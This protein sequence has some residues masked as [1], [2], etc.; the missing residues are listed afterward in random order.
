MSYLVRLFLSFYF[1]L[2]KQD[3]HEPQS[4]T[5]RTLPAKSRGRKHDKAIIKSHHNSQKTPSQPSPP[6]SSASTQFGLT[7][8][9]SAHT[10]VMAAFHSVPSQSS[11]NTSHMPNPSSYP[12]LPPQPSS[13]FV[14][15]MYWPPPNAFLHGPYPSTYACQSFPSTANYTSIQTQPYYN[16]HTS[17]SSFPKLL[18]E[19]NAKNDPASEES[20]NDSNSS[21]SAT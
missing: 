11:Q 19:G 13:A 8:Y 16:N 20:E 7:G 18:L 2:L 15:V 5:K 21:S 12:M 6:I 3:T 10:Y 4:L 9:S 14:P 17:S 1:V